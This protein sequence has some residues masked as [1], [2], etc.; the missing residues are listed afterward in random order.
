MTTLLAR[1]F[2]KSG[3]GEVN[4]DVRRQYG[5]LY[6]ATGIALNIVLFIIKLVAGI[7]SGSMAM[8]ADAI[9]NLSDGGSSLV[10][11]LGF[12]LSGQKPD[13]SH[14]FGHG[15]MEYLSALFV[16][17]FIVFMGGEL[18]IS[19]IRKIINPSEV[20]FSYTLVGVLLI[21]IAVKLYMFYYNHEGAKRINSAVLSATAMDSLSDVV[22]TSTVLISMIVS[23]YSKLRLDGWAGLLVSFFILYTGIVSAKDA[24][25]PLLGTK[26][27]PEFVKKI[28]E[29]VMSFE[30]I[31]GVHD[32]VVHDYGVGRMMISLH[33]EVPA[34]GNIVEIHDTIDN[35]EKKLKDTLG[36]HAVIHMD[37]VYVHD[38]N[39]NRMKRL[40]EL[41]AK[42]VDESLTVHDFRMVM[43][44]THTNLIFDVVIPYEVKMSEEEVTEAIRNKIE[45]LPG[46]LYAV[47]EVDRPLY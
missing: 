16:S 38:D 13:P 17:I 27:D 33:A 29:F 25:D 39:T 23:E 21:S 12:K 7:V 34:E 43:G 47:I 35:I 14:P 19:S 6:G 9:N 3:Q 22:A 11:L 20:R 28:A 36:C 18:C 37:P 5:V 30:G 46:N 42:S 32:L 26:A 41:V 31:Y 4:A 24:V 8:T 1:L 15:R 10:S 45:S 40:T 44:Y 2:I